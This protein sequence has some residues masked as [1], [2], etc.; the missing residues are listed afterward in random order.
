MRWSSNAWAPI[1]RAILAAIHWAGYCRIDPDIENAAA[2][3]DLLS[4][5]V[6]LQAGE[7]AFG[8]LDRPWNFSNA[9]FAI[10]PLAGHSERARAFES[11]L[12]AAAAPQ[13]LA[14]KI[15]RGCD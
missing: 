1:S 11:C 14:G 8:F 12:T 2:Y 15:T 13:W 5:P 9:M 7:T 6:P 10:E 4:L 3:G